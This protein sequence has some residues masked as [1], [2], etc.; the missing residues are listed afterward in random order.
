MS[1][2][3]PRPALWNQYD[4]IAERDKYGANDVL[5]GLTGWAQINGRDELP[6]SV[7]AAY[8]GEYVRNMSLAFNYKCF[9]GI[10]AYVFKNGENIKSLAIDWCIA[11]KEVWKEKY[12]AA[13]EMLLKMK[14]ASVADDG[15]KEKRTIFSTEYPPNHSLRQWLVRQRS[16]MRRGK[17][18]QQQVS[19]INI[20]NK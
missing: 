15:D 14:Q 19:K 16:L 4:L 7:K 13:M 8:D 11:L 1:I 9:F 2:I 3:G 10:I 12:K 6:I 18:S 20:L 17:L 5:P